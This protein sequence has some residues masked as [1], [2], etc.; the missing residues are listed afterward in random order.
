V[1]IVVAILIGP[2]LTMNTWIK[3]NN[4]NAHGFAKN[5]N[6]YNKKY[7]MKKDANAGAAIILRIGTVSENT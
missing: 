3:K 7:G 2:Q 1:T 4:S 6:A 5:D